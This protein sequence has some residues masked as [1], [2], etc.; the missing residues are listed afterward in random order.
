MVGAGWLLTILHFVGAGGLT[1]NS[2]QGGSG[3]DTDQ[4]TTGELLND[5]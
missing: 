4:F 2:T 5:N 1:H 3:G